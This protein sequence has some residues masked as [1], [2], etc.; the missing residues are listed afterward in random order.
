MIQCLFQRCEE[1]KIARIDAIH[2]CDFECRVDYDC[3]TG[4]LCQNY[5]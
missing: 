1:N 2:G 4:F 3:G 5:R